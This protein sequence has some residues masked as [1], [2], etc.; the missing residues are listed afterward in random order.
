M[1]ENNP[2]YAQEVD[3]IARKWAVHIV[4]RFKKQIDKKGISFTDSLLNSFEYKVFEAPGGNVGVNISYE[5]HGKYIDMKNL[6][7]TQLPPIDKI[8]EWVKKRGIE[9]F[10]YIPGYTSK[11]AASADG[12]TAA[13]RIAW[14]IAISRQ[15]AGFVTNSKSKQWRVPELRKG[16]AYLNKLLAEELAKTAS[17]NIVNAFQ[18]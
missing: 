10:D 7:F 17:G 13:R 1:Q 3:R 9:N 14:G 6:Y 4:D 15:K 5:A 12:A 16:I 18:N 8:E 2:Q 11:F